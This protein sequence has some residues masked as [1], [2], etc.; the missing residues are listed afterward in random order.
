MTEHDL[1]TLPHGRGDPCH[2]LPEA[3]PAGTSNPCSP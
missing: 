3:K 2:I 1:P